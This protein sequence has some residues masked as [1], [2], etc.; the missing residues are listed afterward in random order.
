VCCN[1]GLLAVLYSSHLGIERV[2]L[3]VF[4]VYIKT[5]L[6]HRSLS[7]IGILSGMAVN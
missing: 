7:S 4:Y 3:N 1:S 2:F 6:Q 5:V